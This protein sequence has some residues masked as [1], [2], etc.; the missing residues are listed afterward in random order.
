MHTKPSIIVNKN[1]TKS[2][3]QCNCC[4]YFLVMLVGRFS[5]CNIYAISCRRRQ[6]WDWRF[7]F[8]GQKLLN[9]VKRNLFFFLN[10]EFFKQK[11]GIT[12]FFKKKSLRV[13]KIMGRK[14]HSKHIL[15]Q[16]PIPY[17]PH[18]RGE[19]LVI[20]CQYDA[21]RYSCC[22]WPVIIFGSHVTKL[23]CQCPRASMWISFSSVCTHHHNSALFSIFE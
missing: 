8:Y 23:K 14:I 1:I 21:I 13:L 7:D 17:A 9:S 16:K 4:T 19:A 6:T 22:L 18:Y 20:K 11:N 12:Y 15:P 3:T 2:A 10:R 5:I